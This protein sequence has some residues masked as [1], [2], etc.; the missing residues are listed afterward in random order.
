MLNTNKTNWFFA[1]RKKDEKRK[2]NTEKSF[3]R[4][5]RTFR[6]VVE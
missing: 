3:I 2:N 5:V 6:Q 4:V 1:L